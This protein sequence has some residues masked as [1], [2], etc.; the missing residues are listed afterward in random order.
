MRRKNLLATQPPHIHLLVADIGEGCDELRKLERQKEKKMLVRVIRGSRC[1]TEMG[2]FD[3]FAA[4]LQFPLYFG[5]NF[6]ALADSLRDLR[7]FHAEGLVIALAEANQILTE[8]TDKLDDFLE[9]VNEAIA[10]WNPEKP[11]KDG[12]ALH[13]VVVEAGRDAAECEFRWGKLGISFGQI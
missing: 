8:A 13:V 7:H 3:E 6:D 1:R 2:L 12:M 10:H 9:V 5:M 4:A 11:A